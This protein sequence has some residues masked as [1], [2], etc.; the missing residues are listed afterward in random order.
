MARKLNN[1]KVHESEVI[2]VIITKE[3]LEHY[4]RT[5]VNTTSGN[6]LRRDYPLVQLVDGESKVVYPVF[7]REGVDTGVRVNALI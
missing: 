6:I 2:M 7:T 4:K 5:P 3:N 1:C